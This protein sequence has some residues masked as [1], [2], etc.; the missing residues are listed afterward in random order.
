MSKAYKDYL[1]ANPGAIKR[2]VIDALA[3]VYEKPGRTK[4]SFKDSTDINKMLAKAQKAGTL[5]H[6]QKHGAFYGDF[7]NAPEDLFEAREMIE[8]GGQIFRELPAE[9]RAEFRNDPL[10]YFEFVN[11]P[12]NSGRLAEVLPQIAEPGRYFPD[13]SSRT[14]P[15]ALLGETE[16]TTRSE[17]SSTE[18]APVEPVEPS[19]GS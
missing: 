13:V 6:L 9:V 17:P 18:T 8:R 16:A 14:P 11:D 4:Q 7:A 12:A 10:K 15:G 5:S 1:E 3:P 19:D 2:E